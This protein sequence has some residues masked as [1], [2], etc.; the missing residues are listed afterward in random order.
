M[1]AGMMDLL[2]MPEP[3]DRGSSVEPAAEASR[4]AMPLVGSFGVTLTIDARGAGHR[5]TIEPRASAE[6][7]A[8]EIPLVV[9]TLLFAERQMRA[10]TDPVRLETV[11][12]IS[13]ACAAAREGR[14]PTPPDLTSP[15]TGALYTIEVYAN[16][17]FHLVVD[18]RMFGIVAEAA[19][20]M[21]VQDLV[22]ELLRTLREPYRTFF[23][24]MLEAASGVWR[25][26]RPL[27]T[28][29]SW[30]W[31]VALQRLNQLVRRGEGSV[32]EPQVCER[33]HAP[34][35]A[36]FA[37][38]HCGAAPG[39]APASPSAS[40]P[41][42]ASAAEARPSSPSASAPS[43]SAP[44]PTGEPARV[45][46]ASAPAA[47][48]AASP[49]SAA[50]AGEA[51]RSA[52]P[53]DVP[54][55]PRL[56]RTILPAQEAPPGVERP[57][58]RERQ[59]W[60]VAGLGTRIV[61]LI[62]DLAL[63]FAIA[64]IGGFGFTSILITLNAFGP[65]DDPQ[66]FMGGVA[67]LFF[68]LYFVL[69][70]ASAG[71]FGMMIFRLQVVQEASRERCGLARAVVRGIGHL[72]VLVVAFV[73]FYVGN[74]IDNHLVFIQGTADLVVRIIIGLAALYVL[75]LGTGQAVLGEASRQ[76]W[77][78]R[79]ARTL[80]VIEPRDVEVP[81]RSTSPAVP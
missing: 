64:S 60:P 10:V 47:S 45:P 38:L 22:V 24:E 36:G 70:W 73:V 29:S 9:G 80:V 49:V 74:V 57:E 27:V 72:L 50:S 13:R 39:S 58:E 11:D 17:T 41:P 71:T 77:A 12:A 32:I 35:P 78:D 66:G 65:T 14:L 6:R 43:P 54:R 16:R 26:R 67:L 46:S 33:C 56:E 51:I 2:S 81:S 76:T 5:V 42:A 3:E 52:A 69:G 30:S 53:P 44:A 15:R 7:I 48:S 40:P 75:W 28:E 31:P 19:G 79:I 59:R 23:R 37:C 61:A 68:A 18:E 34:R 25:D 1:H 62:I 8:R 20:G 21:A 4:S 63:G 55:D